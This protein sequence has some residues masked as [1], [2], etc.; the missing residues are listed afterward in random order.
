MRTSSKQKTLRMVQIAL[1]VALVIILQMLSAVIK[2]GPVSI[3]LTLVPVVV[4]SILLGASGGF[5]LG[6]A[7]GLIVMINCITG[8]DV[9]GNILWNANPFFCGLICL[10]KGAAAGV[11]PS[12]LYR[13]I[14]RKEDNASNV[15]KYVAVVVAALSAPIVNTGL[16]VVGMF[17]FFTETLYAWAGGTDIVQYILLGLA[18][19][20]FVVEFAINVI[21]SPV[22]LRILDIVKN[23][24]KI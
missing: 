19:I 4:G 13:A 17:L 23:K 5:T 14:T 20:N 6:L 12:L 3:T 10:V 11:I 21:L 18:G 22:I 16:F 8:L 24:I 2:I 15:K 7:F 9:G 1:L